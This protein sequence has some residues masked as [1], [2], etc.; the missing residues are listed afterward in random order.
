MRALKVI[1]P[2]FNEEANV[3]ELYEPAGEAI[4]AYSWLLGLG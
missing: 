3:R 1:T 4:A 2:C